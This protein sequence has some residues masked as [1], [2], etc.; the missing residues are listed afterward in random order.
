MLLLYIIP[1][2][3]HLTSIPFY[4]MDPMRVLVLGSYIYLSGFKCY[5]INVYFLAISLPLIS[6]CLTGHPM[7][8]KNIL[9]SSELV[10]N[11]IFIDFF[12]KRTEKFF[13][14]ILASIVFSKFFYYLLK[15]LLISEGFLR[16]NIIDTSIVVQF[17]I[18]LILSL[19]FSKYYKR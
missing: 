15:W 16:T 13:L 19:L 10:V 18:A 4:L 5:K 12:T 2:L 9:I 3:S 7:F 14:P 1:S 17:S 6:F 11:L 8:P